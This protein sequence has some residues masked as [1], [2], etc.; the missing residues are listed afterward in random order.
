MAKSFLCPICNSTVPLTKDTYSFHVSSFNNTSSLTG[1]LIIDTFSEPLY[2][3]GEE[4]LEH[5]P[6]NLEKESIATL[7]FKCP[8]CDTVSIKVEGIGEQFKEGFSKNIYPSS[9]AKI[10]PNYIPESIRQDYEEAFEIIDLSPKASATLSRRAIQGI[11][12]NKFNLK[13]CKSNNLVDEIKFIQNQVAPDIN[14]AFNNLRQI[15]NIGAHPENDI[16]VIVDI[17]PGEA[18]K[19]ILFVELLIKELYINPYE[20]Q[21]LLD[22]IENINKDK[23]KQ[24]LSNN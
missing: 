8:S 22:E 3:N 14:R 21:I 9:K 17:E 4:V 24:R 2:I 13:G 20:N 1:G 12:R 10:F 23:Q 16:S 5:T 11:I 7:F 18:Q 15:G 19:L 6:K